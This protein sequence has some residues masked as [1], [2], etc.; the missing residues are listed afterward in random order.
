[1]KSVRKVT[2]IPNV[3]KPKIPQTIDNQRLSFPIA[4]KK[5]IDADIELIPI[6]K[7][8][9]GGLYLNSRFNSNDMMQ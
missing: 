6:S 9:K 4:R 2:P 5:I 3:S 7:Y 1:M 8:F